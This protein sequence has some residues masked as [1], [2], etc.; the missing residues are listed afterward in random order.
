MTKYLEGEHLICRYRTADGGVG[1]D[2][3]DEVDDDD[4]DDDNDDDDDD[5]DGNDDEDNT[6]DNDEDEFTIPVGRLLTILRDAKF[7]RQKTI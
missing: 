4:D 7:I 1:D 3:E 5:D 6:S 2:N